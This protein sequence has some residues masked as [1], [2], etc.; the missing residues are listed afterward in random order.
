MSIV[1]EIARLKGAKEDIKNAVNEKLANTI[2]DAM[3]LDYYAG[4]INLLSTQPKEGILMLPRDNPFDGCKLIVY[5]RQMA[6]P[7]AGEEHK[8]LLQNYWTISMGE[9]WEF[10]ECIPYYFFG[11]YFFNNPNQTFDVAVVGASA[12]RNAYGLETISLPKVKE[13][14]Y[15]AFQFEVDDY[16]PPSVLNTVILGSP[17]NPV[18]K[19]DSPTFDNGGIA[20]PDD[21][22]YGCDMLTDIILYY[23]SNTDT[24]SLNSSPWGADN[25][26]ITFVNG[27]RPSDI[28]TTYTINFNHMAKY[29]LNNIPIEGVVYDAITNKSII[30]TVDGVLSTTVKIAEGYGISVWGYDYETL[31]I[32]TFINDIR[33][34]DTSVFYPEDYADENN[35]VNITFGLTNI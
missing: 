6:T 18:E 20:I 8:Y 30:S 5:G 29:G 15:T 7:L 25:A 23:G 22:F 11:N 35:E 3:K 17:G 10:K 27:D 32:A 9:D 1:S 21:I 19:P 13:I 24:T 31:E 33:V 28:G 14:G 16:T 26:T 12:F 34:D 2:Q 4:A